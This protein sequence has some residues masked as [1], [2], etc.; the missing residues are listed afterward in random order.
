M[1]SIL[2]LSQNANG[3][4]YGDRKLLYH[5]INT[6]KLFNFMSTTCRDLTTLDMCVNTCIRGLQITCNDLQYF[7]L[8]LSVTFG[9]VQGGGDFFPCLDYFL[10]LRINHNAN[11][12]KHKFI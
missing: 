1:I 6:V 12:T 11:E 10:S 4:L 2:D 3:Q 9:G 8:K 5:N 7:H